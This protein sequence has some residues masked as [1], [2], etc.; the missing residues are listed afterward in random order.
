VSQRYIL[1]ANGEPVLEPDLMKWATWF[2]AS[3][4]TGDLEH[5][6]RRVAVS[7]IGEWQIS[8]VFLALDHNFGMGPNTPPVLWETMVFGPEPWD[9]WQDRYTSRAAA[10]A[11][12]QAVLDAIVSGRS[13][14]DV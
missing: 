2:E 6:L 3:Q 8:T 9:N 14:E 4:T 12:H 11:G 7:Q 1:D 13:P 10:E 5:S